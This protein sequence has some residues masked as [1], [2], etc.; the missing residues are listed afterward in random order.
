MTF[1]VTIG[2]LEA[3][4][5]NRIIIRNFSLSCVSGGQVT[6][7]VGPNGSGKSTLLRAIAGIVPAK[8]SVL[9][10][11]KEL[12]SMPRVLRAQNCAYQPQVAP[13]GTSLGVLE[14]I[15]AALKVVPPLESDSPF[16]ARQKAMGALER[17]GIEDLAFD[18][19][20]RISGGQ[21]Q[22][23]SLAQVIARP[24]QLVLLDEPTSALDLRGEIEVMEIIRSLALGGA[25]VI[26]V[27]HDLESAARWAD[28]VAVL[29]NGAL[30]SSGRPVETITPDM[31]A[32][33]YAVDARV[34]VR[35]EESALKIDV[36]RPI[37][38]LK[39]N[40]ASDAE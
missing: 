2:N 35:T 32:S 27:L 19:L 24:T 30:F 36:K 25:A 18:P 8:G 38:R 15:I 31:L 29:N 23:A 39:P 17:L 6:A 10:A 37:T 20:D 34:E 1:P 3:G 9:L 21:Q 13:S 28:T 14:S 40:G 12:L 26:V 4:Y 33:V 11:G 5:R 16:D 7:L 22:L